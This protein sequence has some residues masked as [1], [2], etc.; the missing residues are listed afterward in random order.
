MVGLAS[1]SLGSVLHDLV[2]T[3]ASAD[4]RRWLER[5]AAAGATV[6]RGAFMEAFPVVARHLGTSALCLTA[7]ETARLEALGVGWPVCATLDELGRIALLGLAASRLSSPEI[8]AL[9]EDCYQ[10]GDTRERRAVLRALPL[11][12][13]GERL[14]AIA[15]DACRSHV[16]P[17][18]EAI[19]CDNP[20]PAER[21]PELNFNQ[22]VLKALFTG[23]ALERIIG[24][25]ARVTPE[26]RR[27]AN[28]YARERAAAGRSVP[29]DI[30][31][32]LTA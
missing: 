5:A 4:G 32:Y 18:F 15:V 21:F 27:M 28:D 23:V 30:G 2:A 13:E 17:L 6:D 3:H 10:H 9:A 1:A 22:M 26:L 14:L 7:D 8:E 11:L 29:A 20:Y 24:L 19:A 31:R 25:P 12:P 16:Q